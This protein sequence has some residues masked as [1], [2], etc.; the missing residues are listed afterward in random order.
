MQELEGTW[1]Y[2]LFSVATGLIVGFIATL[3]D[4]PEAASQ[5]ASFV[6]GF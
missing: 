4:E 2:T 3:A 1:Y 6:L 5:L